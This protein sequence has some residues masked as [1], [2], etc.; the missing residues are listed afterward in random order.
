MYLYKMLFKNLTVSVSGV[1]EDYA[2]FFYAT[3]N[4]FLIHE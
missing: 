4:E 3:E 2:P 1:G